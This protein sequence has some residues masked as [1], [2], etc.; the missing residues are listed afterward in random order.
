VLKGIHPQLNPNLLH[1][2]ACMGHGDSIA[3]VDSNF[4]AF[5][6][7][8]TL[9][10]TE[11]L[12]LGVDAVEAARV[13]LTV[14]PIDTFNPE[15]PAVLGMQ[16]VDQPQ[17]IPEVV[18]SASPIFEEHH[19]SVALIERF[20]FY[21]AAKQCFAVVKTTESRPYGNFIIRKGVIF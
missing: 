14:L 13:I 15:S 18:R 9:S 11:P 17:E 1:A 2:L 7:A 5:S 8:K 20:A 6:T 4:P 10:I 3:I 12:L 19:A 16:V 21:E